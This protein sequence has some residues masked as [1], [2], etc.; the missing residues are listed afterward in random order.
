ML[1]EVSNVR[2]VPGEGQR[3]WFTDQFFDLILWYD[4]TSEILGFQLC[5]NKKVHERAL[6]WRRGM[7]F[8][9]EKVDDGEAPGQWKMTPILTP[10]GSFDA[11]MIASRF[12]RESAG[13]DPEIARFVLST[14]AAYPG[15]SG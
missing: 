2:Q 15:M 8:S 14:I 3:R 6:T 12:H 1:K 9:H 4:H 13:I 11:A 5:Y 7:G 10:D